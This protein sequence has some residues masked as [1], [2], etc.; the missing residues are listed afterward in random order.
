MVVLPE[1]A[2]AS[3]IRLWFVYSS[4]SMATCCSGDG[5]GRVFGKTLAP[6]IA[7]GVV[8]IKGAEVTGLDVDLGLLVLLGASSAVVH[9]DFHDVIKVGRLGDSWYRQVVALG[10]SRISNVFLPPP[11]LPGLALLAK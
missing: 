5:G 10:R 2:I 8:P 9:M 11:G 6:V 3:M 7:S 4:V 1:P